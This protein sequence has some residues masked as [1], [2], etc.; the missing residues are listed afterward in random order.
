MH[1]LSPDTKKLWK[2]KIGG[3]Q[4]GKLFFRNWVFV[5]KVDLNTDN[6]VINSMNNLQARVTSEKMEIIG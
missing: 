2:D 6:I 5:E 4:K 3:G 1:L